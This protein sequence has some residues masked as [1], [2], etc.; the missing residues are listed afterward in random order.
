MG[1][2]N[3]IPAEVSKR[4]ATIRGKDTKPEKAVRKILRSFGLSFRAN[5]RTLPGC[6]DL[7]VTKKKAAIF[8][9]GCFWHRHYCQG[10]RIPK[11]RTEFWLKKFKSNRH[12]DM[13]SAIALRGAGWRVLIIWECQTKDADRLTVRLRKFL[14]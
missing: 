10:D 12:R 9:H 2:F 13:K 5:V 3:S 4:M 6:P 7:V 14:R 11:S 8:V 1:R